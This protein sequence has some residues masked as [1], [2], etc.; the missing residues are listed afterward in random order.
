[1][2]KCPFCA[3][4]IQDE[5]VKCRFCGEFLDG[6]V[7]AP[8]SGSVAPAGT[9]PWYY[10]HSAWVVGFLCFGPFI[11]P[12]VWINPRLTKELKILIS[13]G[14]L[15]VSWILAK[16]LWQSFVSLK[17]YYGILKGMGIY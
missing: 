14:M 3:E 11:L 15:V 17:E 5:A 4:Q 9:T 13:I 7:T 8:L 10:R 12:L 6:R 1:M 2:K 16:L